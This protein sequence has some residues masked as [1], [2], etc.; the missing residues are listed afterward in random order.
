MDKKTR[1]TSET[2]PPIIKKVHDMLYSFIKQ[3]PSTVDAVLLFGSILNSKKWAPHS[4]IDICVIASRAADNSDLL[5][6]ILRLLPIPFKNDTDM[7]S[8]AYDVQ[9]FEDLPLYMQI[10][11]IQN[12]YLLYVRNNDVAGLYEYFYHY[13]KLWKD[14]QHR[15]TLSRQELLD[16]ATS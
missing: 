10:R 7:K 4:D 1:M 14:Q 8:R 6:M 13:R 16:L 12:H 15:N 2:S 3:L 11:I 5:L 9:M